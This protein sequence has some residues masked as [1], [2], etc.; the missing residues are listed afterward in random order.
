ME[1]LE[2]IRRRRSV[3]RYTGEPVLRSDL[4]AIIDAGR[5]AATGHNRQPWDFV[6][7]T[8]PTIRERLSLGKAWLLEAG[9]IMAVILDP[10]AR[11]WIE[12]GAAAVENM[13]LAAT[14]LGYGSCWLEGNT[15]SREDELKS[16]LGVPEHLRLF[17]LVSVG[18]PAERPTKD[19]RT[20]EDVLH[21]EKF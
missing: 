12:D 17:T 9:A 16:I 7:V 15:Q 11:F 13:L 21:W 6:V 1:A 19:K 10:T 8:D 3:R 18:V 20:L 14:A 4:E 5:L 2:A